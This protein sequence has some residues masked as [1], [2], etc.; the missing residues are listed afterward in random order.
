VQQRQRVGS[1]RFAS[2]GDKNAAATRERF[3]D[4]PVVLLKARS[5]HGG[6]QT[7]LAKLR[8][9]E[10]VQKRPAHKDRTKTGQLEALSSTSQSLVNQ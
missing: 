5:P 10:R 3:E 7:K 1:R 8:A 2:D 9:L 4:T 6:G